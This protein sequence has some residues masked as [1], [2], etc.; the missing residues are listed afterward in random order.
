MQKLALRI[1]MKAGS[2]LVALGIAT[3]LGKK[4]SEDSK[5]Y[6]NMKNNSNG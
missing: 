1:M 2:A 5:E 4:A 3:F 6:R